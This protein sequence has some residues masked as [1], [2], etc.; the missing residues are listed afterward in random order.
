MVPLMTDNNVGECTHA[1]LA[2]V[3]GSDLVPGT[4]SEALEQIE[5]GLPD[6]FEFCGQIIQGPLIGFGGQS[7]GVLIETG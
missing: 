3:G 2:A 1:D 4:G 5:V 7:V 6:S